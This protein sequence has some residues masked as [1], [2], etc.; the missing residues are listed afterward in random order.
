LAPA[1]SHDESWIARV[2]KSLAALKALV[3]IAIVAIY[4][5]MAISMGSETGIA[6]ICTPVSTQQREMAYFEKYKC[7]MKALQKIC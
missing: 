1:Y 2:S 4:S 7:Y 6:T 5:Q 3:P